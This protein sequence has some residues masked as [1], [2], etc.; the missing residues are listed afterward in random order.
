MRRSIAFRITAASCMAMVWGLAVHARQPFLADRER[1]Y[2]WYEDPRQAAPDAVEE[3]QAAPPP[4]PPP[5]SEAPSLEE[6]VD[7][8]RPVVGSVAW[9]REALPKLLEAATDDPSPE[10]VERYFLVQQL[11][12][13]MATEFS[14]MARF[15]TMGH[16]ILDEQQ[17]RPEGTSMALDMALAARV[18]VERTLQRLSDKVGIWF[19]NDVKCSSCGTTARALQDLTRSYGMEVRY[20]SM[21]GS[22]IVGADEIEVMPDNG[23]SQALKVRQGG[24]IVFVQPPDYATV[25]AHGVI[26]LTDVEDRIIAIAYRQGLISDE[27]YAATRPV[28]PIPGALRDGPVTV[29]DEAQRFAS[30]ADALLADR[31]MNLN[32]VFP[33]RSR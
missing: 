16:P 26:S 10:N 1:G 33:T 20:I 18:R 15:V 14:Q 29:S 31:R 12:L 27:E 22:P 3:P 6:F 13:N 25:L 28:G 23:A 32:N 9:V 2:F 21:D 4:P 30:E 11:A 24:S 17:R 8:E 7:P 5:A 19:F